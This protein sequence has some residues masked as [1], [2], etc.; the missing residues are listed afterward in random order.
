[1]SYEKIP[2]E[3]SWILAAFGVACMCLAIVLGLLYFNTVFV[4]GSHYIIDNYPILKTILLVCALPFLLFYVVVYSLGN[5]DVYSP[6]S[7]R[8]DV[9]GKNKILYS[10]IVF[11]M[12]L[13]LSFNLMCI[14]V[15]FVKI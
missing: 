6:F 12:F 4:L 3:R 7:R 10:F 15:Y 8:K 14:Y 5:A 11:M 9:L 1:M 13:F 2:K